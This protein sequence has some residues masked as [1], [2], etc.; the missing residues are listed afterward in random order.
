MGK[1][2]IVNVGALRNVIS[3]SL[4]DLE[5]HNLS[6]V[7]NDLNNSTI[8]KSSPKDNIISTIDKIIDSTEV[9]GSIASLKEKFSILSEACSYIEKI[10]ATEQTITRIEKE[11]WKQGDFGSYVTDD[12]GN[13]TWQKDIQWYK[14]PTI[15]AQINSLQNEITSLE[16]TIDSLLA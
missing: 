10:Q 16:N 7:R 12:E 4:S 5:I 3:S 15:E 2:S 13:K 6:T 8:L 14:D 11:L 1:Y 9:N